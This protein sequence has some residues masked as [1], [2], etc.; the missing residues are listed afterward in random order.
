MKIAADSNAGAVERMRAFT[1]LRAVATEQTIPALAALLPDPIWS[2]P[3][4]S[5]LEIM[6]EPAAERALL[7]ALESERELRIRVGLVN[8]LG[9]R[10][11]AA[12]VP[13]VAKLLSSSERT[14]TDAAI[15]A[16]GNIATVE[17]GT[18]LAAFDPPQALR[19]AWADALLRVAQALRGSNPAKSLEFSRRV[20]ARASPPQAAA[21]ALIAA[22]VAPNSTEDVVA[23][24][25]SPERAA[26]EAALA[27]IRAGEFGSVLTAAVARRFSGL[28]RDVQ[29]QVLSVLYDRADRASAPL[30]RTALTAQDVEVRTAA[31]KLLSVVGDSSD[32]A[33]LMRMMSGTEGPAV[34]A[35]LALARLP[36]EDISPRL[37]EAFRRGGADRIEALEVLVTRGYRPVFAD[38]LQPALYADD[39]LARAAANG[40]LALAR[41]TDLPAVLKLH[42]ELAPAQRGSLEGALRR[43]ATRNAS[44][45]VA[46][47]QVA[48]AAQKLPAG[49][50]EPLYVV[51][52][53]IGGDAAFRALTDLLHAPVVETRKAAARAFANWRERRAGPALLVAAKQEADPSVRTLAV[54]SAVAVYAR[55]A[56]GPNGRPRPEAVPAA[57]DG[58]R[59]AWS[60][61]DQRGAKNAVLTALRG[62]KDPVATAAATELERAD[63]RAK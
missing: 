48:A 3:A 9:N 21:A 8:S 50:A 38:L 24:L 28:P 7:R 30:A 17:A 29:V 61:A 27:S 58:L 40:I 36:G 22:H 31:A 63:G 14:L 2:Y 54:E 34:A 56:L 20:Q 16:L 49:E 32:A 43:V 26:R 53:A 10:R 60:V 5:V 18:A 15:D 42:G 23:G 45:D 52:T 13:A 11:S 33:A 47:A 35:R 51:L 25:A 59:Q 6:P 39:A 57:V 62:L 37:L 44:P 4:R 41:A 46:A 55:N 19:P 1:E 12:A